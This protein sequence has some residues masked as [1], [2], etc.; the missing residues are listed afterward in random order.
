MIRLLLLL[1]ALAAPVSAHEG[2]VPA[3]APR[4]GAT[5]PDLALAAEDGQAVTLRAALGGR[6]TV[7]LFGLMDCD[8][9]CDL[10]EDAAATAL[11]ATGL[12]PGE[13][14]ALFVSLDPREGVPEAQAARERLHPGPA[15]AFLTGPNG[16]GLARA[17]GMELVADEDAHPLALL[18]LTPEGTLSRVLP[19]LDVQP[20]DLR[21]A[22]VEAAGGRIG[23]LSDRITLLCSGFDDATGRYTPLIHRLVQA[24]VVVTVLTLGA[25]ML[26][27]ER[28]RRT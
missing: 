9:L 21:L 25:L 15:W 28:G 22:L 10:S 14:G 11:D 24:G 12:G 7:L 17:A 23:T 1:L 8:N 19:G 6:P 2:A 20:R 5:L 3:F 4:L 18:V 16:A 27:L 13:A 26:L